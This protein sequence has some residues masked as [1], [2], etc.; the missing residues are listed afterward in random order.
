MMI[1]MAHV[2]II[3][4][5]YDRRFIEIHTRG[6]EQFEDYVLGKKT[7]YRRLRMGAGDHRREIGGDSCSGP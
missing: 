2:M 6:F 4:R 5:L 3:E 7:V 1:S